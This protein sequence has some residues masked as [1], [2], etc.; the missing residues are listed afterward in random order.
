MNASNGLEMNS[1]HQRFSISFPCNF[2]ILILTK[3]SPTS[4]NCIFCVTRNFQLEHWEVDSHFLKDLVLGN[5]IVQVKERHNSSVNFNRFENYQ[6]YLR[7][8]LVIQNRPS[9]S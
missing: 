9:C 7:Q 4:D 6:T 8:N 1:P 5:F 3:L 2:A